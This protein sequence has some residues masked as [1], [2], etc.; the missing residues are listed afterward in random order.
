MP[1]CA[2][3]RQETVG[4]ED[5]A[6]REGER[7]DAVGA[8]AEH[9]RHAEILRRGAHLQPE[10]R[11]LEEPGERGEQDR[12]DQD[13][14][15]L[16][17]LQPDAEDLDLAAE[18]RQEV[19]ALGP[20][21]DEQDER[22]LQEEADGEGRDQKRRGIGIA[23]RPEGDA[24]G[25]QREQNC[26]EKAAEKHQRDGLAEKRQERV[27]GDHDQLAMGEVDQPHDAEDEPDAERRQR[28]EAAYAQR[29]H[30]RLHQPVDHGAAAERSMRMPK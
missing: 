8:H 17:A 5:A 30:E 7:D 4:G 26:G 21:A 12:A 15:D 22:L 20:R 2:T 11:R 16:Q 29:I 18:R 24:L 14:D 19:D 25:R 1:V 6:Q 13:G 23:Q 10:A 27:A 3:T 9:A 28:V